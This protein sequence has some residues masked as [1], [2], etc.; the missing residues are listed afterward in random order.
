LPAGISAMI[1]PRVPEGRGFKGIKDE[2]PGVRRGVFCVRSLG[3][4]RE[5]CL[6]ERKQEEGFLWWP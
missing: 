5:P 2:D 4:R 3:E 6:E 1:I